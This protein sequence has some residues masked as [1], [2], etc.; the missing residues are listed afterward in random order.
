MKIFAFIFTLIG[1]I[2][3]LIFSILSAWTK[4][5]N[6]WPA[7]LVLSIVFIYGAFL[8]RQKRI[9]NIGFYIII[10]AVL[11]WIFLSK[12]FYVPAIILIF[13]GF[14]AIVFERDPDI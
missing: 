3:S 12:I 4:S 11:G 2:F 8:I 13:G 5:Y 7:A 14:L 10:L 6:L 9:K 1:G